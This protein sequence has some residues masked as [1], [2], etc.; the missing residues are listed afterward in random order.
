MLRHH[1]TTPRPSAT[2]EQFHRL[3]QDHAGAIYRVAYTVVRDEHLAEDVVQETIIKAWQAL[4]TWRGEGSL[5]GWVLSIAHNTAVSYLRR[6]RDTTTEPDR[7]P[8]MPSP[9]DVERET[10]A[11]SDLER[12]RRALGELDDLSR[13]I[14]VMR[15]LDGLTYQQIA[16]ALDVPL[17]TVKT[18][19]LRARREL[20]RVVQSGVS[21]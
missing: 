13:T 15:D 21:P 8:E 11:R 5:Q 7:I 3:I 2:E 20:Q 9:Y 17:A 18:R 4:P 14:V 19:L 16:D 6:I 1:R 12:L 10:D